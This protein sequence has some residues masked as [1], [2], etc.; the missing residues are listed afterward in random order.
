MPSIMK[1][2]GAVVAGLAAFASAAPAVPKFT[3]DQLKI[4]ELMRRQNALAAAAGLS[5]PDILQL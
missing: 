4:H 2:L 5:D 3:R 1:T